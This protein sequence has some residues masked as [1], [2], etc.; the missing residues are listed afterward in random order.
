MQ[1]EKK[2]ITEKINA[3]T[4]PEL[5]TYISGLFE[6]EQLE[7][8]W[9]SKLTTEQKASIDRGEDDFKHGRYMS[10]Q[11]MQEHFCQTS[12]NLNGRKRP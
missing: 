12:E 1:K 5:L 10:N 8:N 4:S 7:D 3:L 11:Q 6:D 2:F 9:W